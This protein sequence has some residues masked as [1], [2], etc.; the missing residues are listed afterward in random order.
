MR[1][2]LSYFLIIIC[3]L[4]V[5]SCTDKKIPAKKPAVIKVEPPVVQQAALEPSELKVEREVYPYD[6]AGRRDPF[7]PLIEETRQ[8]VKR[9]IGA[10]PIEN[11][12]VDEI[13]L[14]AVAWDSR[15]F[16]AMI[17]LPDKKSYTIKRGMTLGLYGGKV[18]DITKDSVIIREQIKDYKGNLKMKD[19]ILRLR[20]EGEE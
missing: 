18:H 8:K 5:S 1:K 16:Y 11:F 17:T 2:K 3:L 19:T 20:Q 12:D 13:K 4:G 14:I 9:K 7:T 10:T 15:Q 6:P